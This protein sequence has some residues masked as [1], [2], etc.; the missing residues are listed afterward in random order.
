[1][2]QQKKGLIRHNQTNVAK[3]N[4]LKYYLKQLKELGTI[5]GQVF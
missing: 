4:V 5:V 3:V 2:T 1:M